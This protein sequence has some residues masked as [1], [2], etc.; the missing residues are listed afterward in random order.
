MKTAAFLAIAIFALLFS[1][2][3]K[4]KKPAPVFDEPWPELRLANGTVFRNV[5][6]VRYEKEKVVLKTSAGQTAL[7]YSYFPETIRSRM[8]AERDAALAV[9]DAAI[10]ETRVKEAEIAEARRVEEASV[11]AFNEQSRKN[12]EEAIRRRIIIVGMTGADAIRAWGEP[13]KRNLSSTGQLD[14]WIWPRPDGVYYVYFTG[15]I[16][17]SYQLSERRRP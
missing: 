10:K 17:Q 6:L 16:L 9:K 1:S 5:T 15:G 11:A 12:I 4:S 8:L 7:A 2:G 3:A 13:S 14:Q